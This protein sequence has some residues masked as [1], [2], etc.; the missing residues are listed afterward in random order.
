M[1]I[2]RGRYFVAAALRVA[3]ETGV[4][5][6]LPVLSFDK[7]NWLCTDFC[8]SSSALFA[9]SVNVHIAHAIRINISYRIIFDIVIG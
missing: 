6:T 8:N 9:S 3:P 4:Y 7:F 5:V 2:N 1:V